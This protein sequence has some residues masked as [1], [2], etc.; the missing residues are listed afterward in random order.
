MVRSSVRFSGGKVTVI[1]GP[2]AEAKEVVEA[3]A[4]FIFFPNSEA[5]VELRKLMD[6]EDFGD[7]FSP[8]PEIAKVK[9]K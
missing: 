2:F 3:R 1:D 6:I 4:P 8:N 9:F 7:G 5:V